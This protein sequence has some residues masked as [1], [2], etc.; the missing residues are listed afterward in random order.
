MTL[1]TPL[2]IAFILARALERFKGRRV[3]M[4]E[5]VPEYFLVDPNPLRYGRRQ[6]GRAVEPEEEEMA[7][8][9]LLDGVGELDLAQ[10]EY[11][12]ETAVVILEPSREAFAA[13]RHPFLTQPGFNDS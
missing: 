13:R 5:Q 10:V 11:L 1:F 7:A 3:A 6:S 9:V 8:T 4:D 12:L 2:T